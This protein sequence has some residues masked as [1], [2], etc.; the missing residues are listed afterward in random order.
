MSPY[1]TAGSLFSTHP[2]KRMAQHLM[3]YMNNESTEEK[4]MDDWAFDK[5]A[6]RI[7]SDASI[8]FYNNAC[9]CAALSRL[10]KIPPV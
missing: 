3:G 9:G 5:D 4:H 7:C 8:I 1:E 2:A 6:G 10:E